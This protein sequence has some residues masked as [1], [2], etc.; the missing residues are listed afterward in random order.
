M[1]LLRR[2]LIYFFIIALIAVSFTYL[3]AKL[4]PR[5]AFI[6]NDIWTILPSPG[7]PNRDLYTR[8]VVAQYGTFALKKPESAYFSASIDIE[9]E[10]LDGKC[11]YKLTGSDIES[12]WWSITV[13]GSDG[14]LINNNEKQYSFNSENIDFDVNGGFEIFFASN[15]NFI[16]E[17]SNSNWLRVSEVG[18]F[19]ISLRIYLPGEEFFSNLRRVNLPIIEKIKCAE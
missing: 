9:D 12:R 10:P 19:S 6:E 2:Y 1:I 14:F 17:V 13:Y 7:D 11:L 5:F 16:N 8:A 18:S 15:N 4:F 3:S